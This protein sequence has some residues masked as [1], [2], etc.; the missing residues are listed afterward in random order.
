MNPAPRTENTPFLIYNRALT[1]QPDGRIEVLKLGEYPHAETGLIEVVDEAALN[2][3]LTAF[4]RDA[5]KA[6]F[7]GILI[8]EDHF[9]YDPTKSSAAMG[10]IQSLERVGDSLIANAEVSDLG[11]AAVEGK[12]YKFQSPVL[13]HEKIAGNRVR[14]TRLDTLA[15]TNQ[16]V[17]KNLAAITLL[18][19]GSNA[20]PNTTPTG[21]RMKD[22]LSPVLGVAVDA[23][24]AAFIEAATVL[25]NRATKSETDLIEARKERDAL[26]AAQVE[27]DLDAHK[28]VIANRDEVKKQL[29]ANRAGTLALLTS[30]KAP[31]KPALHNRTGKPAP[32]ATGSDERDAAQKQANVLKNRALEIRKGTPALSFDQAWQQA[33]DELAAKQ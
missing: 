30:L 8:D 18:N 24:D 5:A 17:M 16:P 22:L 28:D 10:W 4:N 25:K 14:P 19:R 13:E 9:S 33:T 26:L 23:A 12:R 15:F 32:A 7:A 31:A 3:V 6:N 20:A 27:A 11:R 1:V 29:L 2:A 21:D